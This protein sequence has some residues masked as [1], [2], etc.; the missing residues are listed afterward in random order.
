MTILLSDAHSPG[1][2]AVAYCD[3]EMFIQNW[4]CTLWSSML[5]RPGA[6]AKTNTWHTDPRVRG[7]TEVRFVSY[8]YAN[9]KVQPEFVPRAAATRSDCH[10]RQLILSSYAAISGSN[11]IAIYDTC[12]PNDRVKDDYC[13]M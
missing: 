3:R 6:N 12:D 11:N 8:I 2:A 4:D 1:R 7:E 9:A 5:I 13:T 10:C